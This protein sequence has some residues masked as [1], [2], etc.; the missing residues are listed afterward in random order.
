M[1]QDAPA[2]SEPTSTE[3][4]KLYLLKGQGVCPR[5]LLTLCATNPGVPAQTTWQPHGRLTPGSESLEGGTD[6]V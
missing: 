3:R 2:N 6:G 1:A 5:H 4:D